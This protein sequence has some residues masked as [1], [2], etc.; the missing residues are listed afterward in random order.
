[1]LATTTTIEFMLGFSLMA[2]NCF[3][4]SRPSRYELLNY[5]SE[6]LPFAV[7]RVPQCGV[8]PPCPDRLT[9]FWRPGEGLFD[10]I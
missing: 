9:E 8:T 10:P 5:N 1:M 2:V 6:G 7:Q 3:K 4:H